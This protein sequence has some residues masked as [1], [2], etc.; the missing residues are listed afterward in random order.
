MSSSR[1]CQ[2]ELRRVAKDLHEKAY[3]LE[4]AADVLETLEDEQDMDGLKERIAHA[5]RWA[6]Q[7]MKP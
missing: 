3:E 6:K 2:A 1:D 5:K 7:W 4:K